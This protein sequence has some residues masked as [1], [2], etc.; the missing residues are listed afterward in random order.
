MNITRNTNSHD[1]ISHG[2]S[3][4]PDG[5]YIVFTSERDGNKN[6]Y[7]TS[8]NGDHFDQLTTNGSNDFEPTFSPDGEYIVFTSERD[9]NKEIYIISTI[10]VEKF[11]EFIKQQ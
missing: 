5:E 9:G 2:N 7:I 1:I 8:I 10:C 11:S 3:F 6:I 4:S